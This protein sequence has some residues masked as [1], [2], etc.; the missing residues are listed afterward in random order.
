MEEPAGGFDGFYSRFTDQYHMEYTSFIGGTDEDMAYG[1]AERNGRVV[2]T[3]IT[4]SE[5]GIIYQGPAGSFID[6]T[7][8]TEFM[9]N[10]GGAGGTCFITMFGNDGQLIWISLYGPKG[11]LEPCNVDLDALG[12]IY[13]AGTAYWEL[14]FNA[15]PTA[16]TN[17]P[18]FNSLPIW[19]SGY[20]QSAMGYASFSPEPPMW[21]DG[22]MAKFNNQFQLQW[23]TLFGGSSYF[24]RIVDMEVDRSNG[25]LY[26]VGTTLSPTGSNPLCTSPTG[27]NPGFPWCPG[28]TPGAFFVPGEAPGVHDEGVETGFLAEVKTDGELLYCTAIGSPGM[29][30]NA[31]AVTIGNGVVTVVGNTSAV[32]YATGCTPPSAGAIPQC[33]ASNTFTFPAIPNTNTLNGFVQQIRVG[34]KALEWSSYVGHQLPFDVSSTDAGHVYISGSAGPLPPGQLPMLANPMYFSDVD[35]FTV[36]RGVVLG[37]SPTQQIWGTRYGTLSEPYLAAS[38]ALDRIYVGGTKQGN[39]FIPQNCPSN[40][41]DPWCMH[42]ALLGELC[43]GQLQYELTVGTNES[44]PQQHP[45]LHA[46]PNPASDHLTITGLPSDHGLIRVELYDAIGRCVL[47]ENT[48]VRS[49]SASLRLPPLAPGSY[50]LQVG[51]QRGT[52]QLSTAVIIAP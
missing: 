48:S 42:E 6:N 47:H 28:V 12:N 39:G 30:C 33:N 38:R 52:T 50:H 23:S 14:G 1:V 32:D 26:L 2:V 44:T 3:G 36:E 9:N 49:G 41:V 20:S 45:S 8:G 4:K 22:F 21:S 35:P 34:N 17:A 27:A 5:E 7:I 10:H 43:Y 16:A 31:N 25:V 37:F 11:A 46:Y 29:P 13:L 18:T 51:E 40:A 24:D 19:G 15:L